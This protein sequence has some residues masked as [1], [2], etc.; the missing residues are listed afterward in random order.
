MAVWA[1]KLTWLES[2]VAYTQTVAGWEH[3][4]TGDSQSC[5][6]RGRCCVA[7]PFFGSRSGATQVYGSSTVT[8]IVFLGAHSFTRYRTSYPTLPLFSVFRKLIPPSDIFEVKIWRGRFV[9]PRRAVGG[10]IF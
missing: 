1:P 9:D 8:P 3:P 5:V 2:G 4:Y 6:V 7:S 10:G